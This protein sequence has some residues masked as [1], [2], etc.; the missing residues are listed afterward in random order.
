MSK[1]RAYSTESTSTCTG[2]KIS[3][4]AQRPWITTALQYQIDQYQLSVAQCQVNIYYADGYHIISLL[5]NKV[6]KFLK[7]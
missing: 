4:I 5:M 6:G 7:N 1:I 3:V 2:R